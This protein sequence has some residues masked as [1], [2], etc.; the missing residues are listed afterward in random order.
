[1]VSDLIAA[2]HITEET[3]ESRGEFCQQNLRRLPVKQSLTQTLHHLNTSIWFSS[4]SPLL[5]LIH[6]S[7]FQLLREQQILDL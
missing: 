3:Q 7:V 2:C 1:M 4:R 6:N 5:V